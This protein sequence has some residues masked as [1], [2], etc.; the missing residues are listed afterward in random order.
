MVMTG[1]SV[2]KPGGG[3]AAGY[4]CAGDESGNFAAA[5]PQCG[6]K[7]VT[8]R[9]LFPDCWDGVHLD[10]ADHRSHLAYSDV[11][12][13]AVRVPG[14]PPPTRSRSRRC[15][16]TCP[17]PVSMDPTV[18]ALASGDASTLHADTFFAWQPAAATQAWPPTST[19]AR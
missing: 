2:T 4:T 17:C 11:Q 12:P 16:S 1:T 19:K 7:D 6:G 13:A 8:M 14:A 5:V 15:R 9:V 10:S 18:F 3:L